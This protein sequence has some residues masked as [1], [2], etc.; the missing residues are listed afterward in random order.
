MLEK[1]STTFA[2]PITNQ[3]TDCAHIIAGDVRIVWD[4]FSDPQNSIGWCANG[5]PATQEEVEEIALVAVQQR[6]R[7]EDTLDA[8]IREVEAA[9]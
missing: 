1:L 8:A 7:L 9:L 3:N 2:L 4:D 5:F 6:L